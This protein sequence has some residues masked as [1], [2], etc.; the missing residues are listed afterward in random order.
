[1]SKNQLYFGDNLEVLQNYI[2][3]ESIDLVYL[4]PPFNSNQ[5]YNILFAEKNGSQA[6]AQIKAFGDTWIWDEAAIKVYNNF[7]EKGPPKV[8]Q[9]MQAFKQMLGG[10]DVLAYLAMMA[11]RLVELHRVL[12]QTGSIYLHCD[13]TANHYL[14]ILMDAVFG[15]RNFKNDIIWQRFKFHADAHRFGRVT[16]RILFY[17]KNSDFAFNILRKPFSEEYIKSKFVHVDENGRRFRLSDLNPPSGRGPIY[18]FCGIIRPWRCS[19]EKMRELDNK[20]Y[21]YKKSKVPQLK[22]YLD[23]L[24]GQAVHEL[25]DDISN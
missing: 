25:W 14:K 11:P 19:E 20:G 4:D 3:D 9:V 13:P 16:D 10:N 22:R 17:T 21:I 15:V 6:A 2:D 1:M 24:E 8:S 5:D 12:K 7:V 18:E 23:E